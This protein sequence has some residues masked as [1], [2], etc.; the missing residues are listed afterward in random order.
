[1]WQILGVSSSCDF[2]LSITK[3]HLLLGV[4]VKLPLGGYKIQSW[5]G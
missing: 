4:T 3:V 2:V 1:M 5:A